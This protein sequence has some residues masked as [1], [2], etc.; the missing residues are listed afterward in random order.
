MELVCTCSSVVYEDKESVVPIQLL[1]GTYVQDIENHLCPIV[2]VVWY[3]D[4][5]AV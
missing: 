4:L 2:N 5:K 1:S 3:Q